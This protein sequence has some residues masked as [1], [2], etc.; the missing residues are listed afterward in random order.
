MDVGLE[1]ADYDNNSDID[2]DTDIDTDVFEIHNDESEM[3]SVSD[4]IGLSLEELLNMSQSDIDEFLE[5]TKDIDNLRQLRDE[6]NPVY[7]QI[8][9]DN[10]EITE[11]NDY[12]TSTGSKLERDKNEQWMSGNNAINDVIEARRDDLRDKGMEDGPEMEAIVMAERMDMLEE[13]RRYIDGEVDS[14]SSD[15]FMKSEDSEFIESDVAD[16]SDTPDEVDYEA[17]YEGLDEYDFDG[18]DYC[19]DTERL[20]TSLDNFQSDTWEQLSLD[21]KKNSMNELA[22]YVNEV[23]EFDKMPEIVY[24]NNPVDGDYG[25]YSPGSNTLEVNEYMLLNNEEAADTIAHELWHAYQHQ[26][27]LNP[28]SPKDYQYQYGFDNYIRPED[29][30][31]GYQDQLVEA[32]ARA[33]AQQFKDRLNMKRREN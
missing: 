15:T 25:G 18:I 6:M 19:I 4:S 24:Y 7:I 1:T 16:F 23:I 10:C 33:F 32:E 5:N 22:E 9:E 13:L 17:I 8:D 12:D 29:D 27:T 31:M 20:D 30:F 21:E 2:N 11:S 14:F 26:R 3:E 28:Q